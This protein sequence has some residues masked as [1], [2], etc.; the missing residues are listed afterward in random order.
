MYRCVMMRDFGEQNDKVRI[1]WEDFKA[2]TLEPWQFIVFFS[3]VGILV[4]AF[5]FNNIQKYIKK[6]NRIQRLKEKNLK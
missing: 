4:A 5:I 3:V 2:N 6:K 1:M